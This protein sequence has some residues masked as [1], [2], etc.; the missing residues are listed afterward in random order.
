MFESCCSIA[1]TYSKWYTMVQ[2]TT[3]L[4]DFLMF[5]PSGGHNGWSS[6]CRPRRKPV[7]KKATCAYTRVLEL[8]NITMES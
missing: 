6:M 7:H 8:L 5:E 4:F 3:F 1:S 2:C